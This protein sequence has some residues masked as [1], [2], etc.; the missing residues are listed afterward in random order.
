MEDK[1]MNQHLFL[2]LR[3]SFLSVHLSWS[4]AEPYSLLSIYMTLMKDTEEDWRIPTRFFLCSSSDHH[5][6][7]SYPQADRPS[8]DQ[9]H[10]FFMCVASF[11]S[12]G[13]KRSL[14]VIYADP[15]NSLQMCAEMQ[16]L[17]AEP[18][19][20]QMAEKYLHSSPL[21]VSSSVSLVYH[22]WSFQVRSGFLPLDT[23]MLSS[24]SDS[25]SVRT[26]SSGEYCCIFC[27]CTTKYVFPDSTNYKLKTVL[28]YLQSI[29]TSAWNVCSS[30][31][32]LEQKKNVC[33]NFC[34]MS[35]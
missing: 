11:P 30:V 4:F 34:V 31:T 32:F 35:L 29:K 23:K 28:L 9:L 20:W 22:L 12:C 27:T 17:T 18:A 21:F 26:E 6:V 10:V 14:P 33:I 13:R 8:I 24:H 16:M 15:L 2:Y 1:L 19:Q 5:P 25:F 7:S 3:S